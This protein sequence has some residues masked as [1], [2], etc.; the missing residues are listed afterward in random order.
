MRLFGDPFDLNGDG[1]VDPGEELVSLLVIYDEDEEK[2]LL[3]WDDPEGFLDGGDEPAGYE[4]DDE[5]D[6]LFGLP[7]DDGDE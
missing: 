2:L 1:R 6:G 5:D 7:G 4:D 3:D